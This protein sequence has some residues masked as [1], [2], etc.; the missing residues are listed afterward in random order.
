[1]NQ[2]DVTY[3]GWPTIAKNKSS[4]T[5]FTIDVDR[6]L[7]YQFDDKAIEEGYTRRDAINLL[8]EKYIKGEI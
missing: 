4:I 3:S 6:G 8:M 5:S 7:L 2:L 1:M